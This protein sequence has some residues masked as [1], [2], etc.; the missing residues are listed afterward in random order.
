MAI[1]EEPVRCMEC[2]NVMRQ[3]GHEI[4]YCDECDKIFAVEKDLVA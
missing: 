3:I 2:G 4:F 1:K